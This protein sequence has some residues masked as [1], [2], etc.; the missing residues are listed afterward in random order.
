[1][2]DAMD[3]MQHRIANLTLEFKSRD[4]NQTVAIAALTKQ[5]KHLERA[6]SHLRRE[7][8]RFLAQ[9]QQQQRTRTGSSG[10]GGGGGGG[11]RGGLEI[12]LQQARAALTKEKAKRKED[13]KKQQGLENQI[14]LLGKQ[15]LHSTQQIQELEGSMEK[16][17]QGARRWAKEQVAQMSKTEITKYQHQVHALKRELQEA[18]S[19]LRASAAASLQQFEE[20]NQT[21]S[22]TQGPTMSEGPSVVPPAFDLVGRDHDMIG[23]THRARTPH[24]KRKPPRPPGQ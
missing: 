7:R 13:S 20:A 16:S 22:P 24:P 17:E 15:V 9:Q 4:E 5:N 1:M 21:T 2:H 19:Q 3:A 18:R 8:D 12:H 14:E 23:G 10:G 11:R 6:N